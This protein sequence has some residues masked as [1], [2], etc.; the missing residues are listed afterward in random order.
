[1]RT[2]KEVP[3][4]F[5]HLESVTCDRCKRVDDDIMEIQEYLNYQNNAGYGSVMGDGNE[6]RMDLCQRCVKEVLGPFIR[7]VG[8]YIAGGN[9]DQDLLFADLTSPDQPNAADIEYNC[10]DCN[11]RGMVGGPSMCD[12]CERCNM[13]GKVR[14][15]SYE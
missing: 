6:L 14:A 1:M 7:V 10:P 13:T 11:G 8:N 4:T 15:P 5:Q 2:Y 3:T 12:P 9:F